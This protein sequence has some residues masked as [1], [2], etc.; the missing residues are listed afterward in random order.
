[1]IVDA[2]LLVARTA[3]GVTALAE[4]TKLAPGTFTGTLTVRDSVLGA[5]PVVPVTTTVN[6][7]AGSGLHETERT[8][9][10]KDAVQPAGTVPAANVTVPVNPLTPAT[11]IVEVPAVPTVVRAIVDGLADSEK[12]WTVTLTL[13]V[14]ERVLGAVPVVPVTITLKG[15]TPVVQLTDRTAPEKLAV[16]L[17]G[18][19]PAVKVTVPVNP[20]IGV[21]VTV[22]VPA[23]VASVEMAGADSEKSRIVTLAL[24]VLDSALGAAPV[25]PVTV[26]LNGATPV[27]HVTDSRAPLNVAVQPAGTVPAVNVTTPE[28]PLIG[29]TVTVEVPITV[30][31]VVMAGAES[32]KST[33]WN[34]I[35][36]VVWDNAP[37]L[38]V[39]VTV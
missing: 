3:E 23:T 38:P 31:S 35:E 8:A 20:L 5:V 30:A 39:T 36:L 34:R 22:D 11:E 1:V 4:I 2:P 6:P 14:R 12:S 26:T 28:K 19:V 13:V 33:T 21:T 18:T 27:E 9:P 16:Q 24:A 17:A 29:L 15:A 25:V 7:V 32:E 37:L 10:L